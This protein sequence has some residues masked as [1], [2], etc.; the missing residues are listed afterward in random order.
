MRQKKKISLSF[1]YNLVFVLLNCMCLA[2]PVCAPGRWGESCLMECQ[3]RNGASCDR[4]NGNCHCLP[5]FV[6]S[7]LLFL[8]FNISKCYVCFYWF[9]FFFCHSIQLLSSVCLIILVAMILLHPIFLL[10]HCSRELWNRFL[11]SHPTLKVFF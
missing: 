6:V 4:V 1:L 3:C 7:T 2:P 10:L 11:C 8:L 5:G 9:F